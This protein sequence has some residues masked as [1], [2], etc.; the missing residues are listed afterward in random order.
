M[1]T[2]SHHRTISPNLDY[3]S[4]QHQPSAQQQQ[5]TKQKRCYTSIKSPSPFAQR[6]DLLEQCFPR[7]AH[8]QGLQLVRALVRG[9]QTKNNRHDMLLAQREANSTG[10]MYTLHTHTYIGVQTTHPH[11][12]AGC[13]AGADCQALLLYRLCITTSSSK[14]HHL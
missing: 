7:A 11:E 3:N 13:S 6:R 2:S 14:H 4:H 5:R 9:L 12:S 8:R 10:H 1:T